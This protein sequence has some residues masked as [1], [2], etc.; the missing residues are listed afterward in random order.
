MSPHNHLILSKALELPPI[1][2]AELVE[3]LLISFELPARKR[4]DALWARE[5]EDRLDAFDHGKIKAIPAS[6][7][8]K[9][10]DKRRR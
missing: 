4:I 2:R 8:F 10:I 6:R 7:V 9:E 1:E 5:V 3:S